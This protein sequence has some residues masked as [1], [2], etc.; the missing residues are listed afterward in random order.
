MFESI[1]WADQSQVR[2]RLSFNADWRFKKGDPNQ[3]PSSLVYDVRPEAQDRNESVSTGATSL[4]TDGVKAT[5]TVLKPWI[6]PTGNDLTK[7]PSKRHVR[8]DGNPGGECPY[9]QIDFDDGSW[10][11]ANLP[12]DWAIKGPFHVGWGK[13]VGG[14]MGRLPSP[15]IGWYRKKFTI[16]A[17]DSAKSIFLD[18]DGAMS[19]AVV[20]LNGQLVGG[21]PYGYASW[22]V[23]LA[24]YVVPGAENQLAIR[25][26]NPP[27]S[28]RWYPG[29]GIYRDVWLTKTYPIHVGHWGTRVTTRDVSPASATIDLEVIVD[30]D[31]QAGATVEVISLVFA[32][33]ADGDK[34]GDAVTSF[35]PREIP[36]S[37]GQSAMVKS[38][39]VL[40]NPRLWGPPPTQVPHRYLA[41][42]TLRHQGKAVDQYQTSFGIRTLRFDPETGI[43]I[44]GE[45]IKIKGST[46]ITISGP[47]A[48][49]STAVRLSVNSRFSVRW[50]AMPFV[51]PITRLLPNCS[52]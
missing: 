43:S 30:S 15:G 52:N 34:G 11:R 27:K 25:L 29:G 3:G 22:R 35:E 19:Y 32:L 4:K 31:S 49:H 24:P 8:P 33:D 42:T 38:S 39:L 5:P 2:Q 6:L 1:L 13:G 17:S 44:N 37:A 40:K 9:V 45:H 16:P 47:W 28:S 50:A 51:P 7:D 41:V 48:L 20:W 21:W 23:D 26:D 14:G 12:H 36:I 18:I 10:G 46:C